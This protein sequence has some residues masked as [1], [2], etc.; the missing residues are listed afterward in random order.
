MD[1]QITQTYE[2]DQC[3]DIT[4]I[5]NASN[6]SFLISLNTVHRKDSFILFYEVR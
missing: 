1:V 5:Q 4:G 3:S 6:I 2:K